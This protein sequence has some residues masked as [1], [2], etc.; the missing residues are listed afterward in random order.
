MHLHQELNIKDRVKGITAGLIRGAK[1]PSV[2]TKEWLETIISFQHSRTDTPLYTHN[3]FEHLHG[4]T[5]RLPQED[6]WSPPSLVT[7]LYQAMWQPLGC[8]TRDTGKEIRIIRTI[9]QHH[10]NCGC[11]I[12]YSISS[13]LRKR[14]LKKKETPVP[15][16]SPTQNACHLCTS[17]HC[18]L[19]V[20]S[21]KT[22][23]HRRTQENIT[24]DGLEEHP[25]PWCECKT[26]PMTESTILKSIR[27]KSYREKG[28]ETASGKVSKRGSEQT[29]GK[30]RKT[31]LGSPLSV[32]QGKTK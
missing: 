16:V 27:I 32:P 12:L 3:I 7:A 11:F 14:S 20:F 13:L 10:Y 1:K 15:F 22:A 25:C 28:K 9:R 24:L 17:D 26:E 5:K 29:R 30:R 19:T 21:P 8:E 4:D 23:N 31:Y 18:N 6:T 2:N